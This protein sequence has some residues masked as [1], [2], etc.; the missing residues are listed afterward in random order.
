MFNN[1]NMQTITTRS[2]WSHRKGVESIE[3]REVNGQRMQVRVS[4]SVS[5]Q[6]VNVQ[7]EVKVKGTSIEVSSSKFN[8]PRCCT[9]ASPQTSAPE[10]GKRSSS[11][12]YACRH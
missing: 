6:D 8:S 4:Q 1:F 12:S 5:N 9:Y 2:K 10:R 7:V 3:Y 11:S